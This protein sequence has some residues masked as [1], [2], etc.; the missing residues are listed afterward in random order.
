MGEA[1][2]TGGRRARAQ[3]VVNILIVVVAAGVFAVTLF[4]VVAAGF[5]HIKYAEPDPDLAKRFA[6]AVRAADGSVDLSAVHE[7]AWDSVSVV[8]P[9][10]D[11]EAVRS[12]IGVAGWDQDGA[13]AETITR[14]VWFSWFR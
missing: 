2:A 8:G 3:R 14:A 1:V 6:A 11:L 12:C 13:P 5:F 10:T 7:G 4:F 9:F